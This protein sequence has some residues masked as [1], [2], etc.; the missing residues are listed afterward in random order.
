MANVFIPQAPDLIGP[1]LNI[2]QLRQQQQRLD[3]EDRRLGLEEQRFSTLQDE[4]TKIARQQKFENTM[5]LAT[6]D[7]ES[8]VRQFNTDPDLIEMSGGNME[9]IEDQGEFQ[10]FRDNNDGRVEAV[11]KRTLEVRTVR[12]GTKPKGGDEK[13][14]APD[15][16]QYRNPITG[17]VIDIN[18]RDQAS[19]D[20]AIGAGFTSIGPRAKGFLREE[21]KQ[22]AEKARDIGDS[23]EKARL[24]IVTLKSMD[25][26]LDRFESG[27]LAGFE[28]SLK[29]WAE[30][31]GVPIDIT[32]LSAMQGFNALAEQLALQSRN[33]G[34]GMV[35]AGQM[36]DRDVQFLRDMNPQLILSKGGNRLIIKIRQKIAERQ[37][38]IAD[39]ALEYRDSRGGVLDPLGFDGFIRKR[40]KATSVFGLPEGA[41]LAGEH[42]ETGLPVY[43]SDGKFFIPEF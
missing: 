9:H 13:E 40:L 32:G 10:L 6:L 26:L 11:N 23:A 24:N 29:Q 3:R 5:R 15:V 28:K 22:G 25:R 41:T 17:E 21:G 43:E 37:Q 30:A 39:L 20:Q 31:F 38:D 4:R 16:E 19:I 8:A 42:K 33:M 36:S 18:V 7:P 27:R 35:L 2:Q 1:A 34:E 12:E 14:F